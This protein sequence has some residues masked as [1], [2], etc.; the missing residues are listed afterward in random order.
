MEKIELSIFFFSLLFSTVFAIDFHCAIYSRTYLGTWLDSCD[1]DA[2]DVL[3]FETII[4]FY[5]RSRFDAGLLHADSSWV[6]RERAIL[7]AFGSQRLLVFF[8]FFII[9]FY[10]SVRASTSD[11]GSEFLRS[12]DTFDA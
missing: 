8:Y 12:T 11:G 4:A 2:L 10:I 3:G 9:L 5:P 7:L 6:G 1:S